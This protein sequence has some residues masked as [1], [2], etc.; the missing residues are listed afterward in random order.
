MLAF[1]GIDCSGKSTQ[2][3]KVNKE[4]ANEGHK[5]IIIWSRG[6]YT[7]LLEKIKTL[8]RSDKGATE[9]E[10][11]LYRENINRSN[12]K[13]K[14]LLFLSIIDLILYYGIYFR[15]IE[16]Y[17]KK[18]IIADRYIWDSYI[19]FKMKYKEFNFEK[20]IVWRILTKVYYRPTCS[21]VYVIPVDESMRRSELKN[22]PWPETKEQR[23]ERIRYYKHLISKNKWQYEINALKSIDEVFTETMRAI[24]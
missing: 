7:P 15:F 3:E 6:G 18:I 21:I 16:K 4:L 9:E 12:K 10:K 24:K 8:I 20:W 17:E 13:R 19:D 23:V 11:E 14:L 5:T 22:E 1:S 2:I